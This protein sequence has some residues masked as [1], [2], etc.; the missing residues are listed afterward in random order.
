MVLDDGGLD[1][2][3]CLYGIPKLA[4]QM[5]RY[6]HEGQRSD[7]PVIDFKDS[8]VGRFRLVQ[9]TMNIMLVNSR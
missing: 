1:M 8:L 6:T 4:E 3:T 7:V 5:V 2:A 9:S